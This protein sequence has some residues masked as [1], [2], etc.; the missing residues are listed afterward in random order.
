[1]CIAQVQWMS[2]RSLVICTYTLVCI[3]SNKGR[4]PAHRRGRFVVWRY[5]YSQDLKVWTRNR[6]CLF[7]MPNCQRQHENHAKTPVLTAFKFKRTNKNQRI[8]CPPN[9]KALPLQSKTQKTQT[10]MTNIRLI[11]I[12]SAAIG[13]LTS[14]GNISNGK[15][16]SG[17]KLAEYNE[18]KAKVHPADFLL[19]VL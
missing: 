14:C 6:S 17:A 18:T 16:M 12:I 7:C 15:P 4:M 13:L 9:K 5:G 2:T 10:S 11:L 3:V 1:M 19:V 8:P